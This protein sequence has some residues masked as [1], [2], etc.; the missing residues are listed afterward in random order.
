MPHLVH[1][2]GCGQFRAM[3]PG[4]PHRWH[5]PSY[6]SATF[7]DMI[8]RSVVESRDSDERRRLPNAPAFAPRA[9]FAPRLDAATDHAH[10]ARGDVR[11]GSR[12]DDDVRCASPKCAKGAC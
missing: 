2:R 1:I 3:C 10:A 4:I 7:L 11:R 8:D 9:G 12:V 6:D 5:A